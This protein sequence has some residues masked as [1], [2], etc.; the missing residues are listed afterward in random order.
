MGRTGRLLGTRIKE[1]HNSIKRNTSQV[2]VISEHR[3]LYHEFN[4]EDVEIL[5]KESYLGKRLIS[6]M[7]HIKRQK[8]DLNLYSDTEKLNDTF[9]PIIERFTKI[10]LCGVICDNVYLFC[11]VL[12]VNMFQ[13]YR[14]I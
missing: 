2:S 13:V 10:E 4:W 8:N 12:V 9:I 5:D 11:F 6:E 14:C 7:I 3:L 1:H